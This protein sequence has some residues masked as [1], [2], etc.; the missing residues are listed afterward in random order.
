M[1]KVAAIVFDKLFEVDSKVSEK[2]K[3]LVTISIL[4]I[5]SGLIYFYF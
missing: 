1:S 2:E 4:A 3:T 5:F